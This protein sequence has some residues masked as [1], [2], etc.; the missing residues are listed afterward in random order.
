[1]SPVSDRRRHVSARSTAMSV[2]RLAGADG[3]G[4]WSAVWQSGIARL[5]GVDQRARQVSANHRRLPR[6]A[7]RTWP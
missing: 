3:L 1:M 4:L 6:R 7:P 5:T 2:G